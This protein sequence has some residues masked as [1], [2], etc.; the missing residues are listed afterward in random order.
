VNKLHTDG[1]ANH[2]LN[3]TTQQF[4]QD[5]WREKTTV[6]TPPTTTLNV[7]DVLMQ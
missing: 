1:A 5:P 7:A 3:T 4:D 6:A 2:L